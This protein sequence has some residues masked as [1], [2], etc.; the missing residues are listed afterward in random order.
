VT[1]YPAD[2]AS[3]SVRSLLRCASPRFADADF[4]G[5]RPRRDATIASKVASGGSSS[6]QCPS[7]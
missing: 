2:G 3:R 4:L 1:V 6:L 7:G 5:Y